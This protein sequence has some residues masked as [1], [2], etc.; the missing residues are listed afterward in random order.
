M[1]NRHI[2]MDNRH[3]D[4]VSEGKLD[5]F[6]TLE[7]FHP[8]GEKVQGYR[9]KNIPYKHSWQSNPNGLCTGSDI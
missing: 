3:I 6:K 9:V 7:L 1:D 2:D 5:F 4:V 8:P